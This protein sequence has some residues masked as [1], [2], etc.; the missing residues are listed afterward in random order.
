MSTFVN[1]LFI[2]STTTNS[3]PEQKPAEVAE[4]KST[5]NGEPRKNR[6][7]KPG[8]AAEKRL[9]EG[10]EATTAGERPQ[11]EKATSDGSGRDPEVR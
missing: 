7:E 2:E 9:E 1:N 8:K 6:G 11:S 5:D 10:R 3:W 4:P